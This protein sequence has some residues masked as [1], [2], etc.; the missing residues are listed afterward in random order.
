MVE[1][2]PREGN[3]WHHL[4]KACLTKS[5]LLNEKKNASNFHLHMT[6]NIDTPQII[7]CGK[8]VAG[9][10]WCGHMH[11]QQCRGTGKEEIIFA[12]K[13]KKNRKGGG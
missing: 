3:M 2:E 7:I 8:G 11:N 10:E 4:P 5:S 1:L 6:Q 9:A 13:K 12:K